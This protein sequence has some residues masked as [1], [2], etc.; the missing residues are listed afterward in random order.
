MKKALI[1]IL[2]ISLCF[3]GTYSGGNG[4]EADPYQISNLNDLAELSQTATDWD[5]SFIQTSDIDAGETSEWNSGLGWSPI[6]NANTKFTGSYDG[7]GRSIDSL[8][9]NRPDSNYVGFFGYLSTHASVLN[10]SIGNTLI[11]GS[12]YVGGSPDISIIIVQYPTVV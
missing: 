2:F 6:G 3:A 4:T 7:Q 10:L 5:K 12:G 11:I 8:F 1:L 9:I